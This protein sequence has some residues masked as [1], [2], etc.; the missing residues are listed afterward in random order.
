MYSS[1]TIRALG[2]GLGIVLASAGLATTKDGGHAGM[3]GGGPMPNSNAQ[4]FWF[5]GS[6]KGFNWPDKGDHDRGRDRDHGRGFF[7]GWGY[8][9][10]Y[11]DAYPG[12][13]AYYNSCRYFRYKWRETGLPYWLRRYENCL[14]R[15]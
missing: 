14:D 9:Y 1:K 4:H 15:S 12:D 5:K 6:D 8:P 7:Y 3:S 11:Y 10:P 13:Y 2:L